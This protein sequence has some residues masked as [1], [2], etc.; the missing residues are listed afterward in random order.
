MDMLK[1]IFEEY[2]LSCMKNHSSMSLFTS[3]GVTLDF[4][5]LK[6]EYQ[7]YRGNEEFPPQL[8]V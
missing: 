3:L 2:L 6:N 7:E 5:D 8:L 4:E 1:H